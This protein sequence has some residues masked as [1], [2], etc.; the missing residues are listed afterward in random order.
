M[1]GA[2]AFVLWYVADRRQRQSHAPTVTKSVGPFLTGD[3]VEGQSADGKTLHLSTGRPTVSETPEDR[4][5]IEQAMQEIRSAT[6][7]AL[8]TAEEQEA[9]ARRSAEASVET[10]DDPPKP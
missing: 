2:V 3:G 8:F 1:V 9:A 7:G 10:P 6:E 4:Q 5:A